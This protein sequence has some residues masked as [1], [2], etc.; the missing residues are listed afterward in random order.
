MWWHHDDSMHLFIGCCNI[1]IQRIWYFKSPWR[2]EISY[3]LQA[4]PVRRSSSH[5]KTE[6]W[7]NRNA[8]WYAYEYTL[9]VP[10][11]WFTIITEISYLVPGTGCK[12]C[13]LVLTT[14]VRCSCESRTRGSSIHVVGESKNN[15]VSQR[16]LFSSSPQYVGY[17]SISI[18]GIV[19]VNFVREFLNCGP[20][21]LVWLPN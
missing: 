21:W 19:S 20:F 12:Y 9:L 3:Y 8:A 6:Q 5:H 10:A 7:R 13:Y 18:I 11:V 16:V 4:R 2:H 17:I 14:A 15:S 1:Q